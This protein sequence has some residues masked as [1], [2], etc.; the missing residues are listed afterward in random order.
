MTVRRCKF[1]GTVV[2]DDFCRVFGDQ[3]DV[4]WR[5][6][7]CDCKKRLQKGSGADKNVRLPDP[8]K[9]PNRNRGY[10]AEQD[11]LDYDWVSFRW[12]ES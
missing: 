11:D 3:E 12:G 4:I 1:C 2:S 6:L 7:A 8:S 5:C 9:H 10:L